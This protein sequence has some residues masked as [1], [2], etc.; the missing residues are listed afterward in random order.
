MPINLILSLVFGVGQVV[1]GGWLA[2][3]VAHG[4]LGR[5]RTALLVVV[6]LWFVASG[7]AELFVSGME[8]SLR[9]TGAP[10]EAVIALWRARADTTL[11]V[12]TGALVVGALIYALILPL[13]GRGR[14]AREGERVQ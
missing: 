9:L 5:W 11:Y 14:A 13:I 3:H 1:V 12:V 2:W 6:G 10:P 8:T 4:K 7:G